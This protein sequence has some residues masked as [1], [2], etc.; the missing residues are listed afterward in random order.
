MDEL[1]LISLAL[2]SQALQEPL[3]NLLNPIARGIGN[4]L[5]DLWA[6]S[7]GWLHTYVEKKALIRSQALEDF[8]QNLAHGIA[9]IPEIRLCEPDLSIIGPAMESAKYCFEVPE[10]RR[11]FA[12]LICAT[13][14]S[15]AKEK[16]HPCFVEILRQM[17]VYDA[18]NFAL[19]ADG[20]VAAAQYTVHFKNQ[21]Q[22]D[23]IYEFIANS[24]PQ[25]PP[26]RGALS[27]SSLKRLGLISTTFGLVGSSIHEGLAHS[28]FVT[29]EKEKLAKN[30][31]FS[32]IGII[33]G[34]ATVTSLGKLFFETCVDCI[35]I[36]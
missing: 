12:K 25:L 20:S 14:D 10:L 7:T 26:E 1:T 9:S 19:F 3:S 17:D 33:Y 27:V 8:K 21:P 36:S 28:Q 34:I 6:L 4:T 15:E 11:M 32:H 30:P 24:Q 18:K 35:N 29:Q 16:V 22:E 2:N 31:D 23:Y 5:G 13:I